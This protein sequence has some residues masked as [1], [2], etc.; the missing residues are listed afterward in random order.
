MA[1]NGDALE[2]AKHH[3]RKATEVE[4]KLLQLN[5]SS[6]AQAAALVDIA[7]SLREIVHCAKK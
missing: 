4:V 6:L 1:A 7:Q 5:H 3:L 2:V